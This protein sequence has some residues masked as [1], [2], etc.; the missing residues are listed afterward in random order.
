VAC[1]GPEAP[2][3]AIGR[4]I[5]TATVFIPRASTIHSP[6][7]RGVTAMCSAGEVV[8]GGGFH[9]Y[10]TDDILTVVSSRPLFDGSLSG[11]R[12]FASNW[13]T[14]NDSTLEVFAICVSVS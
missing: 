3:Y 9:Q 7:G 14:F 6:N 8:I 13:N 11:W 4:R 12:V 5:V 10:D 1:A 2:T